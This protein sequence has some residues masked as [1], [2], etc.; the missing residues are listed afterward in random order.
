MAAALA[1]LLA[2]Q[3]WR[4]AAACG[5]LF[6]SAPLIFGNLHYVHNYYAYANSLFLVGAVSCAI[7]SLLERSGW[8]QVAGAALLL[9]A[10]TTEV[11]AYLH[12]YY[13]TQRQDHPPALARVLE[14]VTAPDDVLLIYGQDWAPV[15]PYYA[16][17]RALMNRRAGALDAPPLRAALQG[18]GSSRIGAV[19]FCHGIGEHSDFVRQVLA[20]LPLQPS[21]VV[22][23]GGCAV[24]IAGRSASQGPGTTDQ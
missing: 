19:V 13:L 24:Y 9:A 3:R 11:W 14:E 20:T 21:R 7:V 15:V 16:H 12:G 8:R 22:R 1:V 18:L 10:A 23:V 17:R 4:L 6:L 5:A 2:P